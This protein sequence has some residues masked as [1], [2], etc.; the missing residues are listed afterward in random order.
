LKI[1]IERFEKP[2]NYM[3]FDHE[4]EKVH[5][6]EQKVINE[7]RE[8]DRKRA[9]NREEIVER[10]VRKQKEAY[11]K[12]RLE[13]IKEYERDVLDQKSQPIRQYLMDNLVPILTEGLLE[14]CKRT[15]EDP[16]DYLAEYLFRR[17]L[18]VPYPDPTS[19]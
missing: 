2:F 7:Q 17:S 15:P 3:T 13:Q 8:V 16:V 10:E 4:D 12:Q 19:Y 5:V 6:S 1:Y 9:L 14:V 18:D 11:T